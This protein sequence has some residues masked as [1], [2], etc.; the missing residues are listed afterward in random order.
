VVL[1]RA[2]RKAGRDAQT[3]QAAARAADLAPVLKELRDAGTTSLGGIARAL[4]ERGI[5]TARGGDEWTPM[6]VAR[7]M[8]RLPAGM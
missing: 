1:T 8:A 2:A 4:T 3:A 7:I 5:P 6:Q